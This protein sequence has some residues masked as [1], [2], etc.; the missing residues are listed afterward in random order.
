MAKQIP[1]NIRLKHVLK[2]AELY[3]YDTPENI[4]AYVKV[5]YKEIAPE[6]HDRQKA[7]SKMRN[8]LSRD[9]IEEYINALGNKP[10]SKKHPT[11]DIL[12]ET[13]PNDQHT[14]EQR[15][16]AEFKNLLNDPYS[17]AKLDEL[18]RR[19]NECD[20]RTEE[21]LRANETIAAQKAKHIREQQD[22]K[23]EIRSQALKKVGV[24]I[25]EMLVAK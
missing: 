6:D 9:H 12:F 3:D 16:F 14:K 19:I 11:I 5:H 2:F 17:K 18:D 15:F 1:E 25:D 22:L 21:N 13:I 10:T 24:I 4:W 8:W 20:L 7:Y 23:N